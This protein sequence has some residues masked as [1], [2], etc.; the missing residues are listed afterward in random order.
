MQKSCHLPVGSSDICLCSYL[1]VAY[2]ACNMEPDQISPLE[3][4]WSGFILLVSMNKK[5]SEVH[6][7][8]Q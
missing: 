7:N 6:L 3:A 8:I 2:I 5:L 1:Q 4:V